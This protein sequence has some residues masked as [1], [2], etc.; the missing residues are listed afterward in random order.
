[1]HSDLHMNEQFYVK[2]GFNVSTKSIGPGQTA[3]S[4][5]SD[6]GRNVLLLVSSLHVKGQYYILIYESRIRTK[7]VCEARMTP[8]RP[9]FFRKL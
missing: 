4:A 8:Q 3:Q 2:R 7:C 9:F 6:L 1:M 5:Q